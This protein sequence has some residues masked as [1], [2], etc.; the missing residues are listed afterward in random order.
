FLII[1]SQALI[2]VIF[3]LYSVTFQPRYIV[4]NHLRHSLLIAPLEGPQ[5]QIEALLKNIHGHVVKDSSLDLFTLGPGQ[6]TIVYRLDN[7]YVVR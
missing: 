3:L 2:L 5:N 7:G 1:S 4:Q 6:S